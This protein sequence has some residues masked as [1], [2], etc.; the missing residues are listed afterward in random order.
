MLECGPRVGRVVEPEHDRFRPISRQVGDLRVVAVHDERRAGER[1]DGVPPPRGDD[2]ELAVTVE[3]VAEEVREQ[4]RPRLQAPGELGKRSLVDLEEP[5]VGVP[6]AEEGGGDPRHEVGPGVV[7]DDAQSRA[8]Y[9]RRHRG[10]RRL[11]VRRRDEGGAL[12][13]AP[14]ELIDRGR[15]ELPQ[16]LARDGRPAAAPGEAGERPGGA[17]GGCLEVECERGAHRDTTP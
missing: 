15:V 16:Q 12:R 4:Q 7:V 2:L 13:Q 5:E 11:A 14:G 10:C 8:E 6:H 17:Q 9:L 3:L 1:G